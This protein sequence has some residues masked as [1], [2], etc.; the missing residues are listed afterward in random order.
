MEAIVDIGPNAAMTYQV[1]NGVM[2]GG[3]FSSQDGETVTALV[4][5]GG[6][7]LTSVP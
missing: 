6:L 7:A 4:L 1:I 3:P 2:R 5:G